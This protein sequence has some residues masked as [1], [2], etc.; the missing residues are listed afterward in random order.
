MGDTMNKLI[1]QLKMQARMNKTTL[2]YI[3][4][5]I[6]MSIIMLTGI[7]GSDISRGFINNG[8]IIRK[9]EVSMVFFAA[10]FQ[11]IY[12]PFSSSASIFQTMQMSVS[13]SSTRKIFYVGST[14]FTILCDF[15]MTSSVIILLIFEYFLYKLVG[16][17]QS[18]QVFNIMQLGSL[19]LNIGVT[20]FLTYFSIFIALSGICYFLSSLGTTILT[21]KLVQLIVATF[22]ILCYLGVLFTPLKIHLENFI[23]NNMGTLLYIKLLIVG[24]SGLI[25]S[26]PFIEKLDINRLRY[27]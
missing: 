11:L 24:T 23:V 5:M 18:I 4:M 14:V 3:I 16:L 25:L 13:M 10:L 17:S 20:I 22:L 9:N 8:N 19:N 12:I 27:K 6:C 15:V 2:S 1:G 7:I 26:W 21:G